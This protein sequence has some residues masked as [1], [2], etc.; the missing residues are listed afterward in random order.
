MGSIYSKQFKAKGSIVTHIGIQMTAGG[1]ILTAVGLILGEASRVNL[2]LKGIGAILYLA[3]FGSILAYS[4]YIYILMRWP[5]AKA[6]TYAYV[7]PPVAIFLGFLVLKE[8]ISLNV[9]VCSVII[10]GGVFLVQTSKLKA[11]TATKSEQA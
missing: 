2:S 10:L 5:A 8:P 3:L 6:G 9:I 7:N 4:C 1:A 11:S